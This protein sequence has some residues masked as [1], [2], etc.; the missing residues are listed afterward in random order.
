MQEF[1]DAVALD[2][3]FENGYRN[4]KKNMTAINDLNV[5]PVPDGD[6]GLNMVKTFGGGLA[7]R[8]GDV[9]NVSEYLERL[10]RAVLLSARGNS[11]VIFSQFV[12][13]LNR[14]FKGKDK[15]AFSD[16]APAFVCAKEDSYKAIN[17]PTEGT[18]LTVIREASEFL[19][20]NAEKYEDFKSGMTALLSVMKDS[21]AKTPELLPVLKEAGVVDSGGAGLVCFFEGICA[22]LCGQS[23]ED[24]PELDG[25]IGAA[26]DIRSI[27]FGPDS[28]LEYGYCT[29]F[30]LQLMN[31]K[32]DLSAFDLDAFTEPLKAMG[33]SIVSVH[34]AGIVKIHI[35]TFTPEKVLEYAR[36]FGEFVTLK[37]E[38]M[39][40]QHSEIEKKEKPKEKLEYAI[41][42]VASGKGMC[43]HFYSIGANAVIDG[44]QTNNPSVDAFLE[45]F[46]RFDAEHIIVLPNNSNI[47]LTAKQ[48]AE[49]YKT[50]DV[51]VVETKS[52]VEGYSAIAM[53]DIWSDGIDGIVDSMQEA[54]ENVT[55]AY[56]TTA[57]RDTVMDGVEVCKGKY[58]GL[59]DKTI[60]T[61]TD[62]KLKC[63]KQTI[64]SITD[65]NEKDVII[66]FSGASVTEHENEALREFLE[67]SYPLCDIGFINGGQEV[68]DFIISLE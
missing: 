58:I 41:V 36:N 44:G 62:D 10:S 51:R 24:T 39:S 46:D 50:C 42:T 66:V 52:I 65:Q 32:T 40:V 16:F 17:Q 8:D 27:N 30:I 49:M 63:A 29:E 9:L 48:A 64:K 31:Y 55:T 19:C 4:L 5:F 54:K 57:T 6:T 61:C 18:I 21:L 60:L 68:Y 38:N 13:G 43:E 34:N 28:V 12:S 3:L 53:M 7:A 25:T 15:I 14:G 59:A 45:A 67:N 20:E 2:A 26:S 47:I 56:V 23:V 33:D 35:H 11:G 22:Y 37:I 1:F